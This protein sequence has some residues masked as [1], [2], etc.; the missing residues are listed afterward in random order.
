MST[1]LEFS[2]SPMD[3]GQSL[4]PH[5]ARSLDLIDRSG[6]DY[7]LNPM[8]TVLEGDWD[9]VFDVVKKCF[10]A[11]AVDCDRI[12]VSI[13]VD[14]RKGA[15]GRLHDKTASIERRLGREMKQ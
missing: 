11:M 8:G 6:I 10:E 5:V 12:A 13:K 15:E 3:K 7:R 14:W 1:L 4:S 9:E 2:I